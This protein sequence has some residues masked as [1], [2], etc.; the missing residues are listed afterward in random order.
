MLAEIFGLL[1]GLTLATAKVGAA[2][3]NPFDGITGED[4]T[5][6]YK[7]LCEDDLKGKWEPKPLPA[8]SCPGGRWSNVIAAPKK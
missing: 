8:D 1:L 6:A 7:S 2:L 4:V 3:I 5:A